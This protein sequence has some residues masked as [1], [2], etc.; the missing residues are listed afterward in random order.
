MNRKILLLDESHNCDI[1]LFFFSLKH[2]QAISRSR[3]ISTFVKKNLEFV[4]LSVLWR[5]VFSVSD[6]DECIL[7][8][9]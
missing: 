1:L 7:K 3:Y 5:P 2:Y 6:V 9:N 8:S 4:H